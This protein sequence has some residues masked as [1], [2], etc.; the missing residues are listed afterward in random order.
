[1]YRP[2]IVI[3][4]LLL[5]IVAGNLALVTINKA[6]MD[7]VD[8][9]AEWRVDGDTAGTD[10]GADPE[11]P[12]THTLFRESAV[13]V[14][15]TGNMHYGRSRSAAVCMRTQATRAPPLASLA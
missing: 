2:N 13:F 10:L 7:D 14:F 4:L 9:V 6:A 15:A 3:M 5:A 1:M 11:T 12:A 8:A